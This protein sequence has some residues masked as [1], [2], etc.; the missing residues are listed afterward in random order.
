MKFETKFDIVSASNGGFVVACSTFAPNADEALRKT[1]N[2]CDM[3]GIEAL[4]AKPASIP[5]SDWIADQY[6]E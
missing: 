3:A 1:A 2:F 6:E 5:L 4:C